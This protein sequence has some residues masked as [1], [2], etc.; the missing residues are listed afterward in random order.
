LK[1][2]EQTK[3]EESTSEKIHEKSEVTQRTQMEAGT[4]NVKSVISSLFP[5]SAR[6]RTFLMLRTK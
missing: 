3:E 5:S 6:Q 2:A 4:D 1:H